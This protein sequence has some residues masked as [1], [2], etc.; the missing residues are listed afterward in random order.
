MSKTSKPKPRR[1][2]ERVTCPECRR[3]FGVITSDGQGPIFDGCARSP[4]AGP[5]DPSEPTAKAF[6]CPMVAKLEKYQ[7]TRLLSGL[8]TNTGPTDTDSG[9]YQSIALRALEE[10]G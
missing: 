1:E 7:Y 10:G 8:G 9:G 5:V 2:V 4:I 3:F 6:V